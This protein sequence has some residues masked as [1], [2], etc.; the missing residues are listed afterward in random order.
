MSKPAPLSKSN[1]AWQLIRLQFITLVLVSSTL[2]VCYSKSA[3]ISILCGGTAYWIAN[4]SFTWHAFRIKGAANAKKIVNQFYVGEA[5]KLAI[6]IGISGLLL[7]TV[8]PNIIW[9][10]AGIFL[11]QITVAWHIVIGKRQVAKTHGQPQ[12]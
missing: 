9:F 8:K 12:L 10:A 4:V 5:M 11:V 7:K 1:E 6:F 2:A 3:A